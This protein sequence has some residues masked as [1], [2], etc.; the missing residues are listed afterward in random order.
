MSLRVRVDD[1]PYTK[2]H[3]WQPSRHSLTRFAEFDSIIPVRY[4]LGI[5]PMNAFN[6]DAWPPLSGKVVPGMHG[7]WHLESRQNEFEGHDLNDVTS[8]LRAGR[9]MI[10]ERMGVYP[11]VYMPPHN[12]VDVNTTIACQRVGFKAITG[13]P[14]IHPIMPRVIEEHAHMRYLGSETPFMYGRSDEISLALDS[15]D[16]GYDPYAA[17]G[18]LTLHWTWENNIGFDHLRRFIDRIGPHLEDFDAS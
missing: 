14:G 3:E 16:H 10:R 17:G 13:G 8:Y 7:Y 15:C 5:V 11:D 9:E 2:L 12:A 1:F 6:V 18:I 4:L